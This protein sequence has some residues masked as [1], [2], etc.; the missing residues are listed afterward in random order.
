MRAFDREETQR[1]ED[2]LPGYACA[3]SLCKDDANGRFRG[4]RTYGVATYVRSAL[5][6]LWLPRPAWDLEGRVLGCTLPSEALTILNAYAPNGTDK[7]YFDHEVGDFVGD[8]HAFKRYLHTKVFELAQGMLTEPRDL[9]LLGDWNVSRT[10]LDVFPRLRTSVPHASARALWNSQIEQLGLVDAYRELH[11]T[12]R[13]YTWFSRSAA[14]RGKLDAARVDYAL[15][16]RGASGR[17]V[18]AT[19]AQ[20]MAFELGSDHAPVHTALNAVA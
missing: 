18:E 19:I 4:G 5:E 2:A 10:K 14:R 12:A 16:S 1:I 6:P 9:L 8:R 13:G 11:P 7:P 3:Y 15:L 17:L 20:E